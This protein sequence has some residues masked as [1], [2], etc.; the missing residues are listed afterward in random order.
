MVRSPESSCWFRWRPSCWSE[1]RTD[2]WHPGAALPRLCSLPPAQGGT[3]GE[4][5][6]ARQHLQSLP[7]PHLTALGTDERSEWQDKSSPT[8]PFPSCIPIS[9]LPLQLFVISGMNCSYHKP[10]RCSKRPLPAMGE[11]WEAGMQLL[12]EEGMAAYPGESCRHMIIATTATRRKARLRSL[13]EATATLLFCN[14]VTTATKHAVWQL[15]D[16]IIKPALR[17]NFITGCRARVPPF[18][19]PAMQTQITTAEA[20]KRILER[21]GRAGAA[22]AMVQGEEPKQLKP[23]AEGNG[24]KAESMDTHSQEQSSV[25]SFPQRCINTSVPGAGKECSGTRFAKEKK[26]KPRQTLSTTRHHRQV[27]GHAD[28]LPAD[29]EANKAECSPI[30]TLDVATLLNAS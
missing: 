18:A 26:K 20:S 27:S 8:S 6:R 1:A 2:I 17:E 15:L 16:P 24:R 10:R 13:L 9:R 12:Q 19:P 14:P 11:L 29:V 30:Y 22:G 5:L 28:N 23:S 21:E 3:G 25:C 4:T 7:P